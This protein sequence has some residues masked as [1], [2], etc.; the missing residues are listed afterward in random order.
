[1]FRD[2]G[3]MVPFRGRGATWIAEA[4]LSRREAPRSRHTEAPRHRGTRPNSP[5]CLNASVCR[6]AGVLSGQRVGTHLELHEFSL[7]ALPSLDVPHEVRAVVGVERAPF[8]TCI[9]IVDASV[10]PARV[11]AERI[12]HAQRRPLL[13]LRIED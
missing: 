8:P 4:M 13:R 6:L 1:M 9:R 7:R 5:L 12:R 10:E 11:E 2:A 3:G